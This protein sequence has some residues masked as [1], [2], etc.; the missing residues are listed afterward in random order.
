MKHATILMGLALASALMG[1]AASN[2]DG[3][4]ADPLPASV[5][6]LCPAPGDLLAKGGTVADDEISMG[7][8]GDALIECER[9]RALAVEAYERLRDIVG[10]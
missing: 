2:V 4:R 6:G 3:V 10:G 8:I 7:R 1:C 9:A 5:T